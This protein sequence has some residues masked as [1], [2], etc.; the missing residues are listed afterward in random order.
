MPISGCSD[1]GR[2]ALMEAQ[3]YPEDFNG[4][5]AGAPA[6]NFITQNTFY[7]GWNARM[8]TGEDGRAILT[9]DKLPVLHKAAVDA[10]DELD[11][12]KTGSS[13]FLRRVTSIP[14]QLSA[15]PGRTRR[16]ASL[17]SRPRS[18]A[19]SISARTTPVGR[20]L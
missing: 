12:L 8:N 13:P 17:R 2:E 11:G 16:L 20:S 5:A 19:R 15:S 9:T 1:G 14:R 7:H 18:R 3:R 4:I 6:M 10:C